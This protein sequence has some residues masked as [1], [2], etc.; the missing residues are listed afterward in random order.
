MR[1]ASTS[2]WGGQV[3]PPSPVSR[4]PSALRASTGSGPPLPKTPC[5]FSLFFQT[6]PN[7]SCL[8]SDCWRVRTGPDGAASSRGFSL[9]LSSVPPY[10]PWP[11]VMS[12]SSLSLLPSLSLLLYSVFVI[13][14]PCPASGLF[15]PCPTTPSPLS[16]TTVDG[17]AL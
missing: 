6:S 7:C 15:P 16:L 13:P 2:K 17:K 3:A 8:V 11:L 5:S 4:C 9:F 10:L 14:A 1:E 12:P